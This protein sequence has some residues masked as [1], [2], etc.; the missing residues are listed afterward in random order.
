MSKKRIAL[1]DRVDSTLFSGGD[2]VQ[3]HAIYNFLYSQGYKVDII[4]SFN[5]DYSRYD[6]AILF[7]LNRPFETY[8]YS[9]EVLRY[10]IPYY[11]FPIYWD[12]D[13][14]IP[15]GQS[16]TGI[17]IKKWIPK[18]FKKALK[19]YYYYTTYWSQL[20]RFGVGI[21]SVYSINKIINE[22]LKNA[23]LIF[24]N[25][26]AELVHLIQRF[27]YE[28]IEN[29]S[30]VIKNGIEK[31]IELQKGVPDRL[32]HFLQMDY[33]CCVGGIGP[34]KN[35]L[36][37]VKAVAN[38]NVNLLIIGEPSNKDIDYYNYLKKIATKNVYFIGRQDRATVL[39]LMFHSIGHI[40]P[41]FIE[42]PGLASLEAA[43]LGKPIVVSNVAPVKE[44]FLDHVIYCDPHS[45]VSIKESI[46][47]LLF[48]PSKGEQLQQLV[49]NNYT[50]EKVLEPLPEIIDTN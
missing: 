38:L 22:I 34:R 3:I 43:C 30:I 45:V 26:A 50:W 7:N 40:Q 15:K 21:T 46:Q 41:S 31:E 2:T 49:L 48:D 9:L 10:G 14:V 4:N 37:L 35:Q 39:L 28:V 6:L 27:N 42:T 29:K 8:I 11:I 18:G 33:I 36:N 47:K 1:L 17:N 13:A 20:K 23:V 44:Y 19:P 32:K 5:V 16:S 24:P 12:I 25:S